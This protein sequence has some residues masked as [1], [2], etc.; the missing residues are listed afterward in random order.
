M[1]FTQILFSFLVFFAFFELF[2]HGYNNFE[3]F[4]F[5]I[6]QVIFIAMKVLIVEGDMLS[7]VSILFLFLHWHLYMW[8]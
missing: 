5:M 6:F 8:D 2:E 7:W 4:V 1:H 3:F